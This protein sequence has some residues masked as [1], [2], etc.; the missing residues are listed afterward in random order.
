MWFICEQSPELIHLFRNNLPAALFVRLFIDYSHVY[1]NYV[2]TVYSSD[3]I[4]SSW[5][6]SSVCF[7]IQVTKKIS[8]QFNSLIIN[9]HWNTPSLNVFLPLK[10][11]N[12][13]KFEYLVILWNDQTAGQ[14]YNGRYTN[15]RIGWFLGVFKNCSIYLPLVLVLYRTPNIPR[16]I[17]CYTFEIFNFHTFLLIKLN[18][19][20]SDIFRLNAYFLKKYNHR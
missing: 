10:N 14:L 4:K 3:L 11:Y 5:N 2:C 16:S 1:M 7:I 6:D 13:W 15:Y 18:C 12:F 19:S 9:H 17:N 8:K 20:N